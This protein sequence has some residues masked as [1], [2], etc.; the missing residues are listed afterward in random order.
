MDGMTPALDTSKAQ[1]IQLEAHDALIWD[2][3]THEYLS[4]CMY[5]L[6]CLFK[7]T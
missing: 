3:T 6:T 2:S 7:L 1:F 5:I 4:Y